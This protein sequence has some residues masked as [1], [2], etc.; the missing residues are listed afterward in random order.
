MTVATAT[1]TADLQQQLSVVARK[2]IFFGHQSVGANILD[3]LREIVASTPGAQLRIIR[4]DNPRSLAGSGFFEASIGNNTD[5]E[6]KDRAFAKILHDGFGKASGIAFYKYCYVDISGITDIK[7]MFAHYQQ[8]V[9]SLKAQYPAIRFLHVTVP[10]TTVEP[11]TKAWLKSLL[12]RLT[13][14][15]VNRRRNEF[16][17]LLKSAY[18]DDPVFDLAA[19]ES[20]PP[21]GRRYSFTSD[22]QEVYALFP[23][24]A[25]DRGH[26][27][28]L[29]RHRAAEAL[30]ALLAKL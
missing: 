21:D 10:L 26:L 23:G 27:N 28:T 20:T 7:K 24:Y 15:E 3:G 29:G 17:R 4:S 2:R 12:G 16:N 6:S 1:P 14:R 13:E 25:T 9:D 30:I 22:S 19:I 18:K 8:N 11:P 5:P